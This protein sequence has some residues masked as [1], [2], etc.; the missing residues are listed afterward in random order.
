M[1][2]RAQNVVTARAGMG[3]TGVE[4][5]GTRHVP[6]GLEQFTTVRAIGYL[7][8]VDGLVHGLWSLLTYVDTEHKGRLSAHVCLV[9]RYCKLLS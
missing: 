6:D 7:I 5:G 2:F 4:E 9:G 1:G 8:Q 3:I